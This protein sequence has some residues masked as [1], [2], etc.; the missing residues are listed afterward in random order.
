[1][2][3]DTFTTDEV[4]EMFAG[5]YANANPYTREWFVSLDEARETFDTWLTRHNTHLLKRFVAW[6]G[7]ENGGGV[8]ELTSLQA[9]SHYLPLFLDSEKGRR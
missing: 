2:P 9:L 8:E 1:M 4:R 3:D 7:D 6:L 5:G